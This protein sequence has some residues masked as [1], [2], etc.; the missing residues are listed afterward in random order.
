[1]ESAGASRTAQ[2]GLF[3][4]AAFSGA[5]AMVQ[6]AEAAATAATADQQMKSRQSADEN[7]N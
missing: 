7:V 1:M 5:D 2:A 6:A 3:P 4:Q